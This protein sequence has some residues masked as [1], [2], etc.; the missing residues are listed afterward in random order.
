[1]VYLVLNVY[2]NVILFGKNAIKD[3]FMHQYC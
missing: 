1:M 3:R 2:Y